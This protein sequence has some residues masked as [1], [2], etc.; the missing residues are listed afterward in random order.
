M[1]GAV[2]SD[3]YDE[4]N[5]LPKAAHTCFCGFSLIGAYDY[6]GGQQGVSRVM[7]HHLETIHG[8]EK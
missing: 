3:N 2:M 7:L 6:L 1:S 8:V 4:K 5:V